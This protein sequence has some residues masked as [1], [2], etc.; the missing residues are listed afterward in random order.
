MKVQV[1]TLAGQTLEAEL[2]TEHAASSYGLPV[3]LI[4]GVP[5]GAAEVRSIKYPRATPR[6]NSMKPHLDLARLIIRAQDA[7]YNVID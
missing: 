3:V 1:T 7:G 4:G 6:G 2:T 5:H